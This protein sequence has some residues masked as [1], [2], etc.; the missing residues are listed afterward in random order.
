M[1]Q[2]HGNALTSHLNQVI[3]INDHPGFVRLFGFRK[4]FR[5]RQ[6]IDFQ[7]LLQRTDGRTDFILLY[8]ADGTMC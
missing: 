4:E 6:P 5:E 7:Q 8:G 2:L 3:L 1:N